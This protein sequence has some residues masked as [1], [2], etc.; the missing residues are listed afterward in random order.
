VVSAQTFLQLQHRSPLLEL[1][2]CYLAML[3]EDLQLAAVA[4]TCPQL[5][6]AGRCGFDGIT[7]NGITSTAL[8]TGRSLTALCG[9]GIE[10]VPV[11]EFQDAFLDTIA[12]L[13]LADDSSIVV[14]T[15]PSCSSTVL[16]ERSPSRASFTLLRTFHCWRCWSCWGARAWMTAAS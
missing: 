12:M 16:T 11:D 7:H 8:T 15:S 3:V 5:L 13:V 14:L 2:E 9:A 10:L 6:A 4:K 1:Q